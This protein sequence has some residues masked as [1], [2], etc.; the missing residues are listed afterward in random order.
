M[1][2]PWDDIQLFLAVADTGSLTAAARKLQVTQPT[3]SRRLLEL[4]STLGEALFL[5][6]TEGASL[7]SFGE[8]MLEP[9][10]RMAEWA[11]ETERIVERAQTGPQGVVRL[12]AP[13]GLAF[14]VVAP[15]AGMLREKMPDIRLEVVSTVQFLDLVRRDADLAL[16]FDATAQRD[17]VTVATA[18]FDVGAF[19]TP[20]YVA[21]LPKKPTIADVAWVGWAPPLDHVAPNPQLA[22]LVPGWRPS[23]ASDDFLV[24]LRAAMCGLGAIFLTNMRHRFTM[25]HGLVQVPVPLPRHM[26]T[27]DLVCARSALDVPRVRAVADVIARE[28][29]QPVRRSR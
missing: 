12:T 28:L 27:L 16:R 29:P 4:E 3:A 13:P 23:F 22:A 10:R 11:A 21:T 1:H 6:G 9:A 17:L 5:R 2:I 24:Q 8:R 26:T 7:T 20:E 15:L 25:D 18:R 19:A 14:D